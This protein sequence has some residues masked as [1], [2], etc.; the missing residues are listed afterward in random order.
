MRRFGGIAF[1]GVLCAVLLGV[2]SLPAH[3]GL[4]LGNLSDEWVEQQAEAPI[5]Y[6]YYLMKE[7]SVA[8]EFRAVEEKVAIKINPQGYLKLVQQNSLKT[9]F[10]NYAPGD[11]AEATVA[12]QKAARHDFTFTIDSGAKL[13]GRVYCFLKGQEGYTALFVGLEDFFD[14]LEPDFE[15]V[16]SGMTLGDAVVPSGVFAA[17]PTPVPAKPTTAPLPN[18][19]L[20]L[21][22]APTKAPAPTEAPKPEPTVAPTPA[23]TSAPAASG[24]LPDLKPEASGDAKPDKALVLPED[25]S[26]FWSPE[27]RQYE[28]PMARSVVTLPETIELKEEILPDEVIFKGPDASEIRLLFPVTEKDLANRL[29][30]QTKEWKDHGSS[31]ISGALA[32][33]ITLYSK[34]ETVRMVRLLAHYKDIQTLIAVTLAAADYDKAK[35]WIQRLF[36]D[37]KKK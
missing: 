21:P 8:A 15:A 34:T 31:P 7:G 10:A 20:G 24:D 30:E 32:G 29:E 12:G 9:A 6:F 4:N 5:K 1:L 33:S 35:P 13:K 11:T 2:A 3:A 16:V 37:V 36:A 23:P 22:V 17:S 25:K 26:T 18:P 19:S 14:R 27:T 28:D